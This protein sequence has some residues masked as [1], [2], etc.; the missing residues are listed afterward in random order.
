VA[1]IEQ[2][3]LDRILNLPKYEVEYAI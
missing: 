1:H 2:R 3:I